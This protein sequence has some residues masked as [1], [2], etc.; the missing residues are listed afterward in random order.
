MKI[1]GIINKNEI[2]I[3]KNEKILSGSGDCSQI[4]F[5]NQILNNL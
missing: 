4:K 2:T 3:T 5:K 1:R